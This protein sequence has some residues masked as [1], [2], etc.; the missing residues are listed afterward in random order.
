MNKKNIIKYL[1]KYEL[2]KNI[3]YII[4]N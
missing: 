1:E 3:I 4:K 2:I